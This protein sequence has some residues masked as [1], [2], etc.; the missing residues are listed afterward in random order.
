MAFQVNVAKTLP[1]NFS[2]EP[3]KKR[4][5]NH[6]HR[7]NK[8]SPRSTISA[9]HP[10]THHGGDSAQGEV[11]TKQ[12][13]PG[14]SCLEEGKTLLMSLVPTNVKGLWLVLL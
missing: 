5:H 1:S 2:N 6:P 14:Q 7:T 12:V 9:N 8:V 3:K 4:G 10:Q 11:I 13:T